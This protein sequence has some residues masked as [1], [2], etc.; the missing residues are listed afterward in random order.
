MAQAR[1]CAD[2]QFLKAP[3]APVVPSKVRAVRTLGRDGL[4]E[5]RVPQ[6]PDSEIGDPIE[7]LD[8]IAMSG[9]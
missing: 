6:G 8:P 2:P 4:P 1:D 7:I 5:H 3:H 9:L